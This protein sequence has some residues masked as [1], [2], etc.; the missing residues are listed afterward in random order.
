MLRATVFA[1]SLMTAFSAPAFANGLQAEQFV[2]VA[3][4][5]VDADGQ[6]TRSYEPAGE[7]APGD[8][9]RYRL[10]FI[11]QGGEPVENVSLV[12]PVPV[13]VTYIE[14]SASEDRAAVTFSSDAGETFVSRDALVMQDGETQRLATA[15]EITHIR[16]VLAEAV[17]PDASGQISFSAV[18]K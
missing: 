12:M 13:E 1:L 5:S 6:T 17:A 3:T 15:E 4:V 14:A 16:W 18:L 10:A 7:V 2:E 11:N 9:V 8:E